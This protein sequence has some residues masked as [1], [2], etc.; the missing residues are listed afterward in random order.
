[1]CA[2]LYC[3]SVAEV[4]THEFYNLILLSAGF[5][6][7]YRYLMTSTFAVYCHFIHVRAIICT[8]CVYIMNCANFFLAI[9]AELRHF[10]MLSRPNITICTMCICIRVKT[11]HIFICLKL[12][13]MLTYPILCSLLNYF[14]C[15]SITGFDSCRFDVALQHSQYPHCGERIFSHDHSVG[16]E[17][18][19]IICTLLCHFNAV[20][21]LSFQCRIF[22]ICLI[23]LL[24]ND[25]Q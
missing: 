6:I 9:L 10:V 17:N 13:L 4:F 7:V 1:M 3:S 2:L 23:F 18:L 25:R 16:E 12:P 19:F 14:I 24:Y 8:T 11:S 15:A 22:D 21:I 20:F 5:C